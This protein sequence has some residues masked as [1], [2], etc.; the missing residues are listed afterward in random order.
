[1]VWGNTERTIERLDEQKHDM[2]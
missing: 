2:A 1:M